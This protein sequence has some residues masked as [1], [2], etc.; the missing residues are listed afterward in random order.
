MKGS[1]KRKGKAS[2]NIDDLYLVTL[3]LLTIAIFGLPIQKPIRSQVVHFVVHGL[4]VQ[5]HA[6]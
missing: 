3:I 5:V 6:A 1:K 4:F 2:V